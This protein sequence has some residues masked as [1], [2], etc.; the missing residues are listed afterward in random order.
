MKVL[1]I[2]ATF[3]LGYKTVEL[4]LRDFCNGK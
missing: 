1:I 3:Y 4:F 2:L